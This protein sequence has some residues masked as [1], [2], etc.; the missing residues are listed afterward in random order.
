MV[1]IKYTNKTGSGYVFVLQ[2]GY[3]ENN[4]AKCN[5]RLIT[6]K[7]RAM[8]FKSL[9]DFWEQYKQKYLSVRRTKYYTAEEV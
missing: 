1:N 9:E 7:E 4:L 5:L 8:Q 2:E 3:W 6:S